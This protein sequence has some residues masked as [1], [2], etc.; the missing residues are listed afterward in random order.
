[1][2][3]QAAKNIIIRAK[4]GAGDVTYLGTRAEYIDAYKQSLLIYAIEYPT[5]AAAAREISGK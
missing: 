2:K 4:V 1:M 3:Q 5:A